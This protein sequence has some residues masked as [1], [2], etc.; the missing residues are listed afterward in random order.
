MLAW[1][2]ARAM[3]GERGLSPQSQSQLR[4]WVVM[5]PEGSP[6]AAIAAKLDHLRKRTAI[7]DLVT[8]HLRAGGRSVHDVAAEIAEICGE[9]PLRDLLDN[10]D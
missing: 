1:H 10:H 4:G 2:H 8:H 6:C 9:T 5:A 3:L 7:A